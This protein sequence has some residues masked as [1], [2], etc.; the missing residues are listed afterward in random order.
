GAGAI[1]DIVLSTLVRDLPKPL[2]RAS[3]LVSERSAAKAQ[4]MLDGLG[5]RLAASR[6]VHTRIAS[7]LGD[8]PQVVAE[9]ASHAAVDEFGP[10]ILKTGCDLI[11]ISIGALSSDATRAALLTA[12]EHGGGQIVL[13]AGA[14]GG[15]D[16][17]G[18]ARL[19]GL[20]SLVYT[21]RKSPSAWRGTQAERLV[22][23]DTLTAPATLFEG[24]ARRAAHDFPFNANVAAAL[25]LAG[26]GLD[27]TQ[28]RLIADPGVT[29]NVHEFSVRSAC[30]DFTV[31]MQGR[32]SPA[33]PKTSLMA[34]YCVARE[35]LNRS[36]AIVI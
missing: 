11:V 16:A 3:I 27:R 7:F 4:A 34:G 2:A 36:G 35:L 29:R 20:E 25:A 19:S 26:L 33:N 17:L 32:P 1:A 23:L 8:S 12:A 24:S 10:A 13:P 31:T 30:S 18:A 14:I 15:I 9:C 21:G 6:A 5:D 22:D 28:V